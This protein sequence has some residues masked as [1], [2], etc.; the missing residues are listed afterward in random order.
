LRPFV[1]GLVTAVIALSAGCAPKPPDTPNPPMAAPAGKTWNLVYDV[2][3]DG[4][5]L[6]TT[7][8]TPCFD[9]NYGDCTSSFN[10]G[11]EHYLPSQ[12]QISDG[13]AHLVAEPLNPP[14]SDDAC[15]EGVCTYKSG[16][17]STARPNQSSGYLFPFTYGYVESR[18]KLPATPGMFTAFWMLPMDP[19]HQK[20]DY[21]ID[22]VENL[23]GKSDVVYQSYHYNDRKSSYK[24]NNLSGDTTGMSSMVENTNGKCAKLDYSADFHTYGVD[25][26]PDHVAFYID[27]IECGRFTAT[28]PGQIPNEPMQII[29]DLMVDTKWQRDV[30][31]VLPSQSVTDQLEVDYIKVWQAK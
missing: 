27:G 1:A 14:Y 31:L 25:W 9:W 26:Q 12:V 23:A 29:L 4:G 13:V 6:D 2:E 11:K 16:L 15:F 5:S 20:Y 7:K 24:V 10:N 17:L 3:F 8:L 28:G 30:K 21:E 19:V 22:I 18:M